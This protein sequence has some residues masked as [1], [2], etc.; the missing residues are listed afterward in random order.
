MWCTTQPRNKS[1]HLCETKTR[2]EASSS[3]IWQQT[4]VI[5]ITCFDGAF[6]SAVLSFLNAFF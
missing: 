6:L 1:I 5:M 3:G 2:G 4:L